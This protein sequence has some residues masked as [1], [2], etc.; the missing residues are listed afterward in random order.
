MADNN[1]SIFRI[2]EINGGDTFITTGSTGTR[3]SILIQA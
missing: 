3:V 1:T 2:F